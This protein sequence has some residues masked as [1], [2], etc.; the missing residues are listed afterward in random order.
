[1]PSS[2]RGENPTSQLLDLHARITRQLNGNGGPSRIL[3]GVFEDLLELPEISALWVWQLGPGD[4]PVRLVFQRGL[5][6]EQGDFLSALPDDTH[7]KDQ[8]LQGDALEGDWARG[9]GE[10]GDLLLGDGVAEAMVLPAGAGGSRQVALG[11]L[12][13][14]KES[15][16]RETRALLGTVA[17][18]IGGLIQREVLET[19]AKN[20]HLNLSQLFQA[21]ADQVFVVSPE[22]LVL[23]CNKAWPAIWGQDERAILGQP[24]R[25][26]LPGLDLDQVEQSS[27]QGEPGVQ[28]SRVLMADGNL[29]PVEVRFFAG[30]WDDEPA[31]YLICRNRAEIL[32][33]E[34]DRE[35]L[36]TAIEQSADSILITNSSGTI[37]YSNPAFTRL[38]GYSAEEVQGANPRLLKSFKHSNEFYKAMWNTLNR[39][40]TW[41]GR[42]INRRKDGEHITEFASISPVRDKNGV[43]SHFVAVKRDIT[44]ELALEKRLRQSQKMEAIGTLAGGLAHDFNNILYALLGYCQLAMDDLSQDHPATVSLEEIHKAGNRASNLVSKMLT[45][46][47]RNDSEKV[48]VQLKPIIEEALSLVRASLPST[49][50][51]D[52]DLRES[53]YGVLVDPTQIHQVIVNMATN[54]EYAMRDRGGVLGVKLRDVELDSIEVSAWPSL[55]PGK[56]LRLTVTDTGT[57]M[58][59]ATRERLFEPY[60]TTK[61]TDEGRGLGM[62]TVQGIILNHEGRIFV[63]SEPG[64][65][66]TFEIF[67]PV[68]MK[69]RS[70]DEIQDMAEVENEV[71]DP[72]RIFVVDDE[73]ILVHLQSKAL[74]RLGHRVTGFNDPQKALAAFEDDPQAVDLVI[75]DQTMPS[76]TG[77][78]LASHMLNLRPE[79]P[80]IMAT[81]YSEQLQDVDLAEAGICRLLAKPILIAQLVETV[82]QE[83]TKYHST[84][85]V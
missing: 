83:L 25:D 36:T 5:S 47:C 65:G 85:E 70:V 6:R 45:L 43:I 57:G 34:R 12:S 21:F 30:H 27:H 76:M 28:Q 14:K 13:K 41:S 46:G 50:T 42:M 26:Y 2:G 24:I 9:W 22:G 56:H 44:N 20:H 64:V 78:E 82:S 32:N 71:E 33:M 81:G 7:L 11:V 61:D 31:T 75:T 15:L 40:E 48:V 69:S 79:L 55:S 74:S 80:I 62:A 35:L 72:A 53:Q 17:V 66:T 10:Q 63:D 58:D 77:F 52:V 23:H 3:E 49:I 38:Y 29:I 60:F 37:L 73:K 8:L 68:T 84:I 39:G 54:A 59:E 1:M 16:D 67:L 4:T 19:E 18:Q 51:F